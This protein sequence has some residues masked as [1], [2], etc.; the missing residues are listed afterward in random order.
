M[1]N[2]AIAF[3]HAHF[4]GASNL[5]RLQ[6]NIFLWMKFYRKHFAMKTTSLKVGKHQHF[7]FIYPEDHDVEKVNDL[8]VNIV[9]PV[10]TI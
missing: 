9:Q 6:S 10:L 2:T 5:G 7:C 8:I 1:Q 3:N 4:H